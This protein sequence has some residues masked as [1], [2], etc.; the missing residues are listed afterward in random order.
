[1]LAVYASTRAAELAGVP[2]SE[3]EKAAFVAQQFAAQDRSYRAYDGISFD[4]V[5]VNGEPA[6]RLFVARWPQEIRVVDVALLPHARGRGVGGQLL[7]ALLDEAADGG[8]RVSIHVESA[9]PAKRLYA[10]LGFERVSTPDGGI[11]ELWEAAP[12]GAPGRS[13]AG[14]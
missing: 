4:V 2:W 6:G 8:R 7:A 1:M 12:T 9:N 11:Y 3:D 5:L 14:R 10:R 13:P